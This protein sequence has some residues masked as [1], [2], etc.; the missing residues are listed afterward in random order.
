MLYRIVGEPTAEDRL[1]FNPRIKYS[2]KGND[3][4]PPPSVG[5]KFAMLYAAVLGQPEI[6]NVFRN[7]RGKW[8]SK[9][10]TPLIEFW[11]HVLRQLDRL[12]RQRNMKYQCQ[13]VITSD[14]RHGT[15]YTYIRTH[16]QRRS[17][18]DRST[19]IRAERGVH[20]SR[21]EAERRSD[22]S[23]VQRRNHVLETERLIREADER[24]RERR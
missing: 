8:G 5:S 18:I 10:F 9:P 20:E 21:L 7:S 13:I 17:N 3:Q 24:D 16:H 11:V 23:A 12:F 14:G 6:V 15:S 22:E 4:L 1:W 19:W 2:V